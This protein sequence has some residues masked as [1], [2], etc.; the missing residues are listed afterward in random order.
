MSMRHWVLGIITGLIVVTGCSQPQSTSVVKK[1]AGAF[2]E[3]KVCFISNNAHEFWKLAEVGVKQAGK[4]L[5]VKTEFRMPA[6]AG[7]DEQRQIIEDLITQG[8]AHFAISPN[9]PKNQGSYYDS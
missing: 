8:F 6:R 4:D 9:D 3:L 7:G 5:G 1:P 2:G